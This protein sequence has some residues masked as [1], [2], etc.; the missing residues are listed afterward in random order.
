MHQ[1]AIFKMPQVDIKIITAQ[2]KLSIPMILQTFASLGSWFIFFA[3]IEQLGKNELAISNIIRTVYMLYMIPAWGFSSGINTI[4][5][6]LIG[7]NK[8]QEVWPAIN[9]TAIL[10]FAVTMVLCVFLL[11]FP[12]KILMIG[13]DKP[14]LLEASKRL[15]WVL[16]L[17]LSLYSF[18]I[19]YFNGL[20]GTGA[21]KEALYIQVSCV[22]LYI[23]YVYV[24]V[25]YLKSSLEISWL[26]ETI[27]MSSSMVVSIWYLKS[28]KWKKLSI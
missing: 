24:V 20:V 3:L 12:E 1:Y 15:I 10:C 17:I 14:E 9:K 13:T 7:K 5:S 22:I 4:V 16:V 18:S 26:A 23:I 8:L 2:I 19:I 28:N 25:G 6:N 21:T 27:Y 11:L